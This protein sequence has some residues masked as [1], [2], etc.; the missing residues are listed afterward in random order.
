MFDPHEAIGSVVELFDP[1]AEEKQIELSVSLSPD[2]PRT[3]V[4][5]SA[6]FRQVLVNLVSN[7]V[8]FTDAGT[9][10]VRAPR[11]ATNGDNP[12]RST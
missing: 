10:E 4:G 2:L 9:I 1:Q 5:D 6:R 8:K 3:A 11:P 12:Q 7:A